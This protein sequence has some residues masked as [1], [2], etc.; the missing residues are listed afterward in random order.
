MIR[1]A[2]FA[3][4]LLFSP[5]AFADQTAIYKGQDGNHMTMEI[6]D[7][8]LVHVTG[9]APGQS[10]I[11]RDGEYFL[12]F[13]NNGPVRVFRA[14]DMAAVLEETVGA[15]MRKILEKSGKTEAEPSSAPAIQHLGKTTVAG[16][17]GERYIANRSD[18]TERDE[19]DWVVTREPK[20]A[21]VRAA[22]EKLLRSMQT[23]RS[24]IVGSA[25]ARKRD[26][27]LQLV[28]LGAPLRMAGFG[29]AGFELVSVKT[30]KIDP[31]RF[32]LPTDPISRAQLMEE[33]MT[34][35]SP[36]IAIS[37]K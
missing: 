34:P 3:A 4:I 2:A 19:L 10:G 22:W 23:T 30:G 7:S 9:M 13:A 33:M 31:A 18:K 1:A 37:T 20:L 27:A 14:A 17:S 6:A 29:M 24:S 11:I 21:A 5:A 15:R 12:I 8:G 36:S 26:M 28:A 35:P 32:V 16:F 25:A